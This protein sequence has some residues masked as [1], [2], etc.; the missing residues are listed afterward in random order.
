VLGVVLGLFFITVIILAFMLWRRRNYL[1]AS[2]AAQSESGT[3]DNRRWIDRW[4][5]GTPAD[6]KAPTVTSDEFTNPISPYVDERPGIPELGQGNERFEL[7]ATSKPLELHN[8]TMQD[9][10][11]IPLGL[12]NGNGRAKSNGVTH[13]NSVTSYGSSISDPIA[14]PHPNISP[15]PSSP[16]ADS[17]SI[18]DPRLVSGVS[19]ISEA[20]RSHMRGISETSVSTIGAYATPSEGGGGSLDHGAGDGAGFHTG[21]QVLDRPAGVSPLTPQSATGFGTNDYLGARAIGEGRNP[22]H[23]RSNFSEGLDENLGK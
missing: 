6:I 17:P 14:S 11:L 19:N 3:M 16:L 21:P 12:L 23:R 15:L 1:R 8:Q 13:S 10:G 22:N 18:Q 2:N 7:D 20:E 5:S 9:T 4:L